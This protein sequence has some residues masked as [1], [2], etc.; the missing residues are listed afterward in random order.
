MGFKNWI[1]K[2]TAPEVVEPIT[3]AKA[4]LPT[5]A[6]KKPRKKK[7]ETVLPEPTEYPPMPEAKKPRAKKPRAKKA[8]AKQ[9]PEED[10]SWIQTEKE[11]ATAKG[12]PW[13]KVLSLNIDAD[14]PGDGSFSLDWNLPFYAMLLRAGYVGATEHDVVDQWFNT[15]CR[16]VLAENF[17][18][19]LADPEKRAKMKT[20]GKL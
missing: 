2:L 9:E 10:T 17:E 3:P 20:S 14:N 11:M 13:V 12:E 19:E 5:V 6:P 4:A 15:V 1:H 16:N 8:K 7:V 18:Q